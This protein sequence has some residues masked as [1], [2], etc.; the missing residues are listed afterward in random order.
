[1]VRFG[2]VK[3]SDQEIHGVGDRAEIWLELVLKNNEKICV[4]GIYRKWVRG[5]SQAGR[6]DV[7]FCR[8]LAKYA[9]RKL[10]A[11]GDFNCCIVKARGKPES[12]QGEMLDSIQQLG[13]RVED[14]GYTFHRLQDGAIYR[15][16]LDWAI[17][18]VDGITIEQ[19]SMP[20]TDHAAISTTITGRIDKQWSKKKSRNKQ[21]LYSIDSQIK[22]A[23]KDWWNVYS[24][25]KNDNRSLNE[26]AQE[27]IS[28]I[29]SHR[30]AVAPEK[31]KWS[32]PEINLKDTPQM[33]SIR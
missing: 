9:K 25:S 22:L 7:C 24:N 10:I 11:M 29:L 12:K 31:V 33:T 30:D 20:F 8:M 1:M 4:A 2:V 17:T 15:S 28:E 16:G 21:A 27:L 14:A 13:Y 5:R 19:E 18:N 26:L 6:D 23:E 32:L 3:S